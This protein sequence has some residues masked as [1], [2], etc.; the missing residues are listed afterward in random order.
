M[1]PQKEKQSGMVIG[2]VTSK[3]AARYILEVVKKEE[4]FMARDFYDE[5]SKAEVVGAIQILKHKG[6]IERVGEY[7]IFGNTW[8][9]I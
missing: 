9:R 1:D 2:K 7:S 6:L 3:E 4:P 5:F 8:K